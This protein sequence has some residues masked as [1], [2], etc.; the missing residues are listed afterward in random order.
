MQTFFQV[1]EKLDTLEW[2]NTGLSFVASSSRYHAGRIWRYINNMWRYLEFAP[3]LFLY[4]FA[5]IM[6]FSG[7]TIL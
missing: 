3:K 1:Q 6:F 2:S 4:S 5:S 7:Q